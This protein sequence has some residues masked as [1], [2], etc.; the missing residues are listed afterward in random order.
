MT[1]TL[2]RLFDAEMRRTDTVLHALP[3]THLDWSPHARSLT[4]GRLAMHVATLPGWMS[5][6][7][8]GDGHDMGPGGPGPDAPATLEAVRDAFANAAARGRAALAACSD[9]QL[10]EPW[11][12]RRHD[13]VVQTLTRAEAIAT[14][15]LHHLAHHRGQLTVYLRLLDRPVPALYGDSADVML[16]PD[17]I[18][19]PTSSTA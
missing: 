13:T 11:V 3:A 16:Q 2:L 1:S 9:A 10:A 19:P 8:A 4:L 12:L 14:F 17:G 5:A 6:Y 7:T 15:A 18:D